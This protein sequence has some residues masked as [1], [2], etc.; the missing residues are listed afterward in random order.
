MLDWAA[1][2]TDIVHGTFMKGAELLLLEL[3]GVF[4]LSED[5]S[6]AGLSRLNCSGSSWNM[7]ENFSRLQAPVCVK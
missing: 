3:T 5:D 1:L 2:A 4:R 7:A 6:A